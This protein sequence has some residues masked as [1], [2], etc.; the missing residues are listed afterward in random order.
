MKFILA[1]LSAIFG[2]V[3][4]IGYQTQKAKAKEAT[5]NL[6][7]LQDK[8]EIEKRNASLDR[9]SLADGL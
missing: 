5:K 3:F 2:T 8:H 9:R 4:G 1:I 6:K 7:D